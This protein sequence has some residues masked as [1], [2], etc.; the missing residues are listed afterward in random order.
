MFG[1]ACDES[2]W[3]VSQP[4]DAFY[5]VR[6]TR[7]GTPVVSGALAPLSARDFSARRKGRDGRTSNKGSDKRVPPRDVA[8][9]HTWCA[10]RWSKT[11]GMTPVS[12][13][14]DEGFASGLDSMIWV[15]C[16]G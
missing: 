9:G 12:H 14:L 3:A 8:E 16:D 7:R 1:N 2:V 5:G 15:L 6:R 10:R 4:G 13:V 11:V